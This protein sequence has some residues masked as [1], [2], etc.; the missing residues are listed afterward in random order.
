MASRLRRAFTLAELLV[1]IG[2]IAV[3]MAILLPSLAKAR[4]A[5]NRTQCMSNMRQICNGIQLYSDANRQAFPAPAVGDIAS[6]PDDWIAWQAG[7][8]RDNP[9]A[10]RDL[11][12]SAI[13]P[14]IGGRS[15]L[16][17]AVLTCPSDLPSAHVLK[18][19][20]F[21]YSYTVNWMICEPRM[22]SYP[23]AFVPMWFDGY[24][25]GDPRAR[26]NLKR[27]Q[28]HRPTEVILLIDENTLTIDDG[29]WAPQ[30]NPS[31]AENCLSNRHDLRSEKSVDRSAGRGNV[32][33]CD[34][35]VDFIPRSESLRQRSWDPMKGGAWSMPVQ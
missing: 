17:A 12:D 20:R 9:T 15:P 33:F 8:D 6:S 27:P 7:Y 23:P 28:I 21:L 18:S 10:T 31:D 25:G 14:F 26:A 5:A 4:E 35:H 22:Y 29:C 32:A 13:K 24:P 11:Q 3:L 30:H 16:T 1:V 19:N 34:G 2:I